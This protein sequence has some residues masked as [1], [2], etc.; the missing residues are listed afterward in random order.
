VAN[1]HTFRASAVWQGLDDGKGEVSARGF[2]AEI[3]LPAEFGGGSAGTNAEELL[4][5]ALGSC[6]VMTLAY[7]LEKK[8]SEMPHI[9]AEIEGK[10]VTGPLRL[11]SVTVNL[12]IGPTGAT[13]HA[14]EE[15]VKVA[16]Q[17]CM[18]SDIIRQAAPIEVR[19]DVLPGT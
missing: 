6:F 19:V 2:S 15:A 16:E 12:R 5:S 11:A 17:R 13:E 8:V 7:A 18:V 9:S 10:F 14:I 4:L 3:A 1:E